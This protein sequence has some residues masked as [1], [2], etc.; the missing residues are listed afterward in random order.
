M[1]AKV[2]QEKNAQTQLLQGEK[3][4]NAAKQQYQQGK[5]VSDRE[6]AM[7]SWQAAVD[8]LSKCH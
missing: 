7:T 2:F 6:T 1:E 4:L 8:Q 5:T 3:T